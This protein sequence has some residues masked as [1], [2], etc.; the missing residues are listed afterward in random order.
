MRG[1]PRT[2]S[3]NG[4]TIYEAGASIGVSVSG[5]FPGSSARL[6]KGPSIKDGSVE[7][8]LRYCQRV[9]AR[10]MAGAYD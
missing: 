5:A 6:V 4:N 7:K 2:F 10:A 9:E 8:N 3:P 1:P